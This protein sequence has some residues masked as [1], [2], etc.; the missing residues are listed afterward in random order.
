MILTYDDM[1]KG[2][3]YRVVFSTGKRGG[4]LVMTGRY[5]GTVNGGRG[6]A[7][8]LRPEHGTTALLVSQILQITE[9]ADRVHPPRKTKEWV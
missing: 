8:D 9:G 3:T 5:L 1:I 6:V 4:R 7:F 2:Q